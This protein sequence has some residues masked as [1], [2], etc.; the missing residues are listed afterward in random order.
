MC[1]LLGAALPASAGALTVGISDQ[2]AA[3]FSQ[4]KFR[5]IKVTVARY[6][7]PWNTVY[8]RS[9]M[10]LARAWIGGALVA[11]VQPM[12]SF[13]GNGNYIPTLSQYS[14]AIRAFMRAFPQVRTY[15]AWNEPDWIYR[16]ALANNP[17]LAAAYFN[18]LHQACPR[19]TDVAGEVY[20]PASQLSGYMRA[21]KRGL[22][23]RP[24]A[25]AL[26]NYYDV[27]THTTS[28]LRVFQR[29]TSGPI[30][31]TEIAGIERRGH[32]QYANQSVF[33]AAKDES[34]LFSLPRRFHRV[35][36]IY[37]YNWFGTIPSPHVGWD[38]GLI[39]PGG[40]PRPAYW[41]VAK[42][43]GPR[44]TVRRAAHR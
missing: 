43:A 34:F 38:S 5:S 11:G 8:S 4:P 30:W 40:V 23:Y 24:S 44:H 14:K 21:Y 36:R 20:L 10:S 3:T 9:Q 25:W 18:T 19:C 6:F 42:A 22:H 1:A 29:F 15:A 26:H 7:A 33:A 41:V 12:I 2:N 13:G 35:T 17:R 31:L 37:H 39:G 28:Q 32:W 16:P 27:R